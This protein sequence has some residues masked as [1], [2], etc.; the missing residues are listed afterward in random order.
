VA[1][2]TQIRRRGRWSLILGTLVAALLV[3]AVAYADPVTGVTVTV[4]GSEASN[5]YTKTTAVKVA[6]SATHC[7]PGGDMNA[8]EVSFRNSAADDWTVVKAEG[9]AWPTGNCS[10]VPP[11]GVPP[12]TPAEFD[13]TLAAGADGSRTVFAQLRHGSNNTLAQ[14]DIILDATPP[15]ITDHGATSAPN[16]D[17]G[18][19]TSAVT[20]LF[21]ADDAT[22]GLRTTCQTAFPLNG[23][24]GRNER[25]VSSGT[26]EGS[27]VKVNSGPCSDVASNTNNGI[28]SAAFMIDLSDPSVAITAPADGSSTNDASIAVS[29]TASDAISG[30]ASVKLTVNGTPLGTNAMLNTGT[31]SQSGVALQCGSNTIKATAKDKA[32]R[33]KD[34][35]QISVTRD[36]VTYSAT[37]GS[38]IDAAPIQ[39]SMKVGRVLPVKAAISDGTSAVTSGV[40]YIGLAKLSSCPTGDPDAVEVFADAGQSSAGSNLFRWDSIASQW[41]YNL[42][43]RG[44][45]ASPT[46]VCYRGNVYANGSM[47]SNGNGTGGTLAGYFLLRLTSK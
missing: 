41:V 10:G 12:A 15:V 17:N 44:M 3:A 1:T 42:D 2:P 21:S 7:P 22:S 37:F 6:V 31:W 45:Q 28:D 4:K 13:W 47:D 27:A 16:G 35:A 43:T 14:D 39:N 46:G 24:T 36:C 11:D 34:S 19:Y 5:T 29:G 8:I 33:T 9:V 30:L 25:S 38:P 18:W 40:V 20:N 23:V 26:S 32:G